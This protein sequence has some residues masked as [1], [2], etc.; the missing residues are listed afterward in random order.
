MKRL[1]K[2]AQYE[3]VVVT[4]IVTKYNRKKVDV[5]KKL[6]KYIKSKPEYRPLAS[7]VDNVLKQISISESLYEGWFDD[8]KK[9]AKQIHSDWKD[10]NIS[11]FADELSKN[12]QDATKEILDHFGIKDDPKNAVEK[13][14]QNGYHPTLELTTNGLQTLKDFYKDYDDVI[15]YINQIN[16][17]KPTT[18][19]TNPTTQPADDVA[20][21]GKYLK[22][23]FDDL[24]KTKNKN[25]KVVLGYLPNDLQ[26]ALNKLNIGEETPRI[27]LPKSIATMTD[28]EKQKMART[29]QTF[30][31]TTY[32]P[33]IRVLRNS[34]HALGIDI[35]NKKIGEIVNLLKDK[36]SSYPADSDFR[37]IF[38]K[39]K[40]IMKNLARIRNLSTQVVNSKPDAAIDF[41]I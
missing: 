35:D 36:V 39:L 3:D 11:T 20:K 4:Q 19:S 16:S 26:I 23:Y 10:S 2:E 38:T 25:L 9:K 32:G 14:K 8:I 30:L 34:A 15:T 18:G 28:D 21:M 1:L 22:S 12:W 41:T 29:L 31:N 27:V 33:I 17:P 24:I 7:V 5:L 40:T 37:D 13:L 6:Q